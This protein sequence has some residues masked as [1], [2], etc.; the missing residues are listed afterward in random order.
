MTTYLIYQK[1]GTSLSSSKKTSEDLRMQNPGIE[2]CM[3]ILNVYIYMYIYTYVIGLVGL[4]EFIADGILRLA[5]A[6]NHGCL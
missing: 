4:R 1:E 2:L 6:G 5:C 3:Y